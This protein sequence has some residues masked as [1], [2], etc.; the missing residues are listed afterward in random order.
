MLL[1]KKK[2]GLIEFPSAEVN[3]DIS[4]ERSCKG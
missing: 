3:C 4:E 1:C 2:S